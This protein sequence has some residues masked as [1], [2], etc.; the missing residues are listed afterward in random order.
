L[1]APTWKFLCISGEKCLQTLWNEIPS[2]IEGRDLD[3]CEFAP[4]MVTRP[5]L[6]KCGSQYGHGVT[7]PS[8][9][10]YL[11]RKGRGSKVLSSCRT[12]TVPLKTT[13]CS[14]RII[15]WDSV[16]ASHNQALLYVKKETTVRKEQSTRMTARRRHQLFSSKKF[17]QNFKKKLHG[18]LHSIHERKHDSSTKSNSYR[19]ITVMSIRPLQVLY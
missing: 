6:A 1:V 7:P 4:V 3:Q 10:S 19:C 13:S 16:I 15:L 8:V 14:E 2:E 11:A 12:I 18:Y 5:T 17:G 9:L